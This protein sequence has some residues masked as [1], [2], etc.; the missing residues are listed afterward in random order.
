MPSV[1]RFAFR[2]ELSGG[3]LSGLPIR[4]PSVRENCPGV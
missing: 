4:M 2:A 3:L 1:R